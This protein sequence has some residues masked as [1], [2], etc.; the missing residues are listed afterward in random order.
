MKINFKTALSI[1]DV[2]VNFEEGKQAT[3]GDACRMVLNATPAN[4]TLSLEDMVR[5]GRLSLRIA[6]EGECEVSV[7]DVA[8]IRDGLTNAF[9]HPELVVTIYDML[10]G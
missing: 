4:K 5:R 8:M 7:E 2:P 3:L 1:R 9:K 10:G 6:E